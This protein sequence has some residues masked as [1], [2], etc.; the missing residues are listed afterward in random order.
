MAA[1]HPL[2]NGAVVVPEAGEEWQEVAP[3]EDIDRVD[4]NELDAGKGPAH[5]P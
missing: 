2:E 3:C 5:R 4:L 1:R